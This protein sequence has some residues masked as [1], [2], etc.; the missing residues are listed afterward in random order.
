[1]DKKNIRVEI[2]NFFVSLELIPIIIFRFI[3]AWLSTNSTV[4]KACKIFHEKLFKMGLPEETARMLTREYASAK[5]YIF[6]GFLKKKSKTKTVNT[7]KAGGF[8]DFFI[9]ILPGGQLFLR[10]KTGHRK[11]VASAI[12][13]D[14]TKI[15]ILAVG[16]SR[17]LERDIYWVA[18]CI[19]SYVLYSSLFGLASELIDK[20]QNSA[21]GLLGTVI[22]IIGDTLSDTKVIAIVGLALSSHA[23]LGAPFVPLYHVI[24]NVDFAEHYISG[25]GIGLFVVKAYRTFA[26]HISYS[27]ALTTFGSMELSHQI[28]LFETSAELPFVCYSII[29]IGLVWE[30]LEEIAEKFT[31]R[32]VS[33]FFWNGVG[34]IVMNLLGALTA[35]MLASRSFIIKKHKNCSNLKNAKI[36]S[37]AVKEAS[38]RTLTHM[39]GAIDS[40]YSE[41]SA[42]DISKD[43]GTYQLTRTNKACQTRKKL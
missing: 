42:K 31:S 36:D 4:N 39:K 20:H 26:S 37:R 11:N 12:F 13:L 30:G 25:F 15:I 17:A 38:D 22:N 7:E 24:P 16:I 41:N 18:V 43:V 34:D 28:S 40:V 3:N 10:I 23:I 33:V 14:A 29:F 5:D 9:K 21:K 35:Y 6:E 27:K 2:H 32:V 8:R 19:V 1:M